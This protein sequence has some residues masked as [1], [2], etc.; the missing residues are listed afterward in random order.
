MLLLTPVDFHGMALLGD[1]EAMRGEGAA[2]QLGQRVRRRGD[3]TAQ[4]PAAGGAGGE[5]REAG[6]DGGD[7]G[8]PAAA[9]Q[10]AQPQPRRQRLQRHL[11]PELLDRLVLPPPVGDAPG[12]VRMRLEPCPDLGPLRRVE[13]TVDPGVQQ[14]LVDRRLRSGH[15]TLRSVAGVS[16][17]VIARSRSRARDRRDMT[18]PIGT[19]R[20]CA[21]SW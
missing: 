14:R 1:V 10:R 2:G 6:G 3:G 7:R 5:Q 17:A 9:Q 19:S 15:F 21:T 13:A 12:V 4:Q 11:A 8:A 18:V 20:I 16:A